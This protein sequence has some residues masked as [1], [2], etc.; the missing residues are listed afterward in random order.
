MPSRPLRI[1]AETGCGTS[2]GARYCKK[3][4]ARA[5]RVDVAGERV[6]A[7]KRGYGRRWEKLRRMILAR[8]PLCRARE[9]ALMMSARVLAAGDL[10]QAARFRRLAA[11]CCDGTRPSTDVDHILPRRSGGEDS[12]ENLGGSC[13]EDHSIKTAMGW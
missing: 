9:N 3:H 4:G 12:E 13:H 1:C 2:C 11:R 8:D 7:C 10:A 6:S 5:A